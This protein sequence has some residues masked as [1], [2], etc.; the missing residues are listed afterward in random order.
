MQWLNVVD[1]KLYGP[2]NNLNVK[3][4]A[5]ARGISFMP[6]KYYRVKL[7]LGPNY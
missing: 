7:A 1:F 5:Q 3:A 6:S 4:F 2:I